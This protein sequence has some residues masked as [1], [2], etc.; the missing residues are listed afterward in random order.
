MEKNSSPGSLLFENHRNKGKRRWKKKQKNWMWGHMCRKDWSMGN[1]SQGQKWLKQLAFPN[2]VRHPFYTWTDSSTR[3]KHMTLNSL[4]M[5]RQFSI[6]S[7]NITF[8]SPHAPFQKNSSKKGIL[9]SLLKRHTQ[10]VI[11]AFNQVSDDMSYSIHCL[12]CFHNGWILKKLVTT[13]A[14]QAATKGKTLRTPI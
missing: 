3:D 12:L 10:S 7:V 11:K 6:N 4:F 5:S 13:W 1:T 9:K 2:Y 14:D 8:T